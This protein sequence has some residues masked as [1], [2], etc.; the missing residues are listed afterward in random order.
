MGNFQPVASANFYVSVAIT[1]NNHHTSTSYQWS[2]PIYVTAKPGLRGRWGKC[3]VQSLPMF[4]DSSPVEKSTVM[5][6]VKST[7][8]YVEIGNFN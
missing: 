1:Q 6:R 2:M 3:F 5:G 4:G 8:P 7:Q